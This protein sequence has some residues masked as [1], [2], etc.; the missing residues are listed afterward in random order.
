MMGADSNSTRRQIPRRYLRRVPSLAP[1]KSKDLDWVQQRLRGRYYRAG[2]TILH[3]GVHGG[4]LG[5]VETG[6]IDVISQTPGGRRLTANLQPG[7]FFILHADAISSAT[8]RAATPVVLWTLHQADTLALNQRLPSA[9]R[10][11]ATRLPGSL[12]PL[13]WGTIVSPTQ[14]QRSHLARLSLTAVVLLLIWATLASPQG[15]SFLADVRYARGCW[16]LEHGGANKAVQEFEAALRINPAHAASYNGLGYIYYQRGELDT[17]LTAFEQASRLAPNSDVIQN[18][19]GL[20]RNHQGETDKALESLHR[21][22]GLSYNVPQ[23]YVNLGN[24]YL[25]QEDWLNAG[26]A[27]RE[28]LRLNPR[29]AATH[30]NLG[31]T[32]YHLRQWIDARN[33]FDRALQ[34]DPGLEVACVGL[35]VVAFEQGQFNRAQTAF[36]RAVELDPQD[37][38]AYFYLGLIHENLGYRERAV[39]AFERA[40]GLSSDPVVREQAEWHLK[41]LWELP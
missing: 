13:R 32:C 36:Q 7:D 37:A 10:P 12:F 33:E 15:Q 6:Q 3:R 9:P 5:I 23:V 19:L 40:L 11:S 21:A 16:H 28:A 17:A 26:R 14:Q 24:L 30:Y 31:M 29:L 18:N 41:A 2:E 35:G 8:L 38:V 1:L 39:E 27:Y 4:F 22:A 34:L 20:V 25:A